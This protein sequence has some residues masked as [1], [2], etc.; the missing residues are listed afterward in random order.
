MVLLTGDTKQNI[1]AF[2]NQFK[3][4]FKVLSTD[5]ITLKTIIRAYPGYLLLHKGTI[6]AKWTNKDLPEA[7][8]MEMAKYDFGALALEQDQIKTSHYTMTIALALL[9]LIGCAVRMTLGRARRR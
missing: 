1:E 9:V 8:R 2:R 5:A 7:A 3:P 6:V 4:R